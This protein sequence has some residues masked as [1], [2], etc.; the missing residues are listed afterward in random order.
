MVSRPLSSADLIN[1]VESFLDDTGNVIWSAPRLGLLLV[2]A[3]TEV[4]EA[5]PYV[6]RDTYHI[7]SRTGA[8]SST[9]A[10]STLVDASKSPFVSGSDEGKVVH[11]T[12]DK[13]WAII[14]SVTST[15][16]AVLSA[17]IF[18]SGEQYEIYNAG[19]W[20]N[21]QINIDDS[22]DSLWVMYA[23]YPSP[24]MANKRNVSTYEDRAGHRIVE[25]DVNRVDDSSKSDADVDVDV[26]FARQHKVNPMTDLS[27]T[28]DKAG[29]YSAAA[30]TM[31]L[32]GLTDADTPIYKDTLFTV[33]LSSGI[34]SRLT[35]RVTADAA[36][37]SNAATITFTP[38]L[39]AAVDNTAVVTFI[40]ST[41]PPDLERIVVQIII[42][43]ALMSQAVP[44]INTVEEG[45]AGVSGRYYPI[46]EKIAEKARR[47]LKALIDVDLRANYIHS[48]A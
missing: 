13:T 25:L 8:A 3:V 16:V 28:V 14:E 2:D 20:N 44:T 41:L 45:G 1:Q 35:Y 42:G 34:T 9:G 5:V 40:G 12:T 26:Y 33:A 10:A 31:I 48:R 47:Q 32:N 29:G 27:A 23:V 6:M 43:E 30:I 38:G 19:C 21:K 4:S 24:N 18:A 39:E 11:N 7:E 36:I 22:D 46:G 15:S 17:D 37:S